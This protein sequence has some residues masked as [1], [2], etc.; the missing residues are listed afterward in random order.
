LVPV[1]PACREREL[2]GR[3]ALARRSLSG[4]RP[5]TIVVAH[6]H[7][8]V[9]ELIEATLRDRGARVLATLDSLEA[10]EIVRRLK[11]DLLVIS[12][13]LKDVTRDVRALQP[14]LTVVV[15]DDE[16]MWL[17]EIAHA[18]VT[19]LAPRE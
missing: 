2:G 4:G 12:K 14:E 17:D 9:L 18:V 16:P 10:V 5:P 8:G 7:A 6:E 1:F 3:P 19:A 13:A 15:L 11:V